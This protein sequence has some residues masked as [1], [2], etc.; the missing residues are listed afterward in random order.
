MTYIT[1]KALPTIK[2]VWIINKKDF[3]IAA[4]NTNSKTFVI[5]MAIQK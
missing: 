1:N 3:I 4:L 2:Q 5:Y